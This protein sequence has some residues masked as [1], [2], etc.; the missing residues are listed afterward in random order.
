MP[1][2][3]TLNSSELKQQSLKRKKPVP[4]SQSV[5][6][7]REQSLMRMK[8]E[9]DQNIQA[10]HL[11][12]DDVIGDGIDIEEIGTSANVKDSKIAMRSNDLG[13]GEGEPHN[14]DSPDDDEF[15]GNEFYK[16]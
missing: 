3:S 1:N 9:L 11:P 7:H 13:E 12:D 6:A 2:G 8:R 14:L 10:K 4:H 15:E 5:Q 16:D